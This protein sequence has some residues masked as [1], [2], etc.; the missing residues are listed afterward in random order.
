M[1]DGNRG[2]RLLDSAALE[3]SSVVANCDM[4]RVRQLAG[5]NSYAR[6]L[7]FNPV[8]VLM[9][10]VTGTG[11]AAAW[12]DLCC[13]SG[14]ALIQAAET[15]QQAGLVERIA[16]VGV[17][18]VD[19]F[20]PAPPGPE[21]ICASVT[22]W[23]PTQAFDLITCLHGLHY[24]GDKLAVLNRAASWLTETGRLVADI[25]LASIRLQ[26]GQPAGKRLA[27][28]LRT[29]GFSYD[30][31]RHRISCIGPRTA[32]LPYRYLGADDRAGAN[33]TGQ[34]AVNSYYSAVQD[35]G[36]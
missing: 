32:D 24:V 33:Y 14:R 15:L 5:V 36:L 12:L 27:A 2:A 18:L 31:R 7:G 16:L 13:G 28:R 3:A 6:E 20:D 10:D 17:D 26:D 30:S 35:S 19:A 4:N 25:D 34:P 11:R 21:L 22:D 8:D 29:V 23:T 1:I 9:A